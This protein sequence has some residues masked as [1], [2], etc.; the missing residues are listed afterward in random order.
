[1]PIL[2]VTMSL[3][4]LGLQ[5][6]APVRLSPTRG[7]MGEILSLAQDVMLL[8]Q[9][10][11]LRLSQDQVAALLDIY[12]GDEATQQIE[13]IDRVLSFKERLLRGEQVSP[14][15]LRDALSLL[16]EGRG[17]QT[18]QNDKKLDRVL[19]VLT[20]WQKTLLG[21]GILRFAGRAGRGRYADELAVGVLVGLTR[22]PEQQWPEVRSQRAQCVAGA[23]TG[24]DPKQVEEA[25]G[26]FLDRV[27]AMDENEVRAKADE[28]VEEAN[29]LA[30]TP[31]PV[32]M[33][34]RS[35]DEQEVR[36]RAAQ[37]FLNPVLPSLLDEMAEARGWKAA[38]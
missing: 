22:V 32:L 8:V 37:L 12:R 24:T 17:R 3:G 7:T 14:V 2:A 29:A 19:D 11:P 1:M 27:H 15:E 30:T 28:L 9:I 16:R 20:D 35:V 38:E 23:A 36:R 33:L 6:G 34:L 4:L 31:I 21:G 26:E 18:K 10:E 13:A 25:V 5:V